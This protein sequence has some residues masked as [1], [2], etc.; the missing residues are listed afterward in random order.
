MISESVENI[1]D[2]T[3]VNVLD[4]VKKEDKIQEEDNRNGTGDKLEGQTIS[5]RDSKGDR[6]K[7]K[8]RRED[9]RTLIIENREIETKDMNQKRD[10]E[11]NQTTDMIEQSRES[12]ATRG[13]TTIEVTDDDGG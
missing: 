13:I 8:D 2:R 11:C 3:K 5:K 10:Q 12:T 4:K 7:E 1:E 6:M 9:I